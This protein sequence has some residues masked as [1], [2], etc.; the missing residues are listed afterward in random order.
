MKKEAF[1]KE[2]IEGLQL[3]PFML[4]Y[5]FKHVI[6]EKVTKKMKVVSFFLPECALVTHTDEVPGLKDSQLS[7][8]PFEALIAPAQK[9]VLY[10]YRLKLSLGN[11]DEKGIIEEGKNLLCSAFK[12]DKAC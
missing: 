6:D 10:L 12:L 7:L 3:A 4:N 5:I 8:R 11:M 2:T 9:S 1:G